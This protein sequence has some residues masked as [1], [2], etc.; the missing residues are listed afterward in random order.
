M[1]GLTFLLLDNK[2]HSNNCEILLE[3]YCDQT[4]TGRE[5][6]VTEQI[7]VAALKAIRLE[8]GVYVVRKGSRTTVQ[9]NL[10]LY[11]NEECRKAT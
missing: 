4:S 5:A 7:A 10:T 9:G 6:E 11:K 8:K 1:I 2:K 3:S